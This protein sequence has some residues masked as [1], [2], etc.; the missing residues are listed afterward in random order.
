MAVQDVTASL[1]RVGPGTSRRSWTARYVL[2]RLV[3]ERRS[4]HGMSR[5]GMLLAGRGRAVGVCRNE[6]WIVKAG[7]GLAVNA[8]CVGASLG[9]VR[10]RPGGR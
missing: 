3:M 9:Q 10:P 4:R 7:P 6:D 5:G 2:A 1:G 8:R